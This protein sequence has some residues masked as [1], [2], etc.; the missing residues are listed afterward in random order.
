MTSTGETTV[1]LAEEFVVFTDDDKTDAVP[2]QGPKNSGTILSVDTSTPPQEP[3]QVNRTDSF[4]K[5]LPLPASSVLSPTSASLKKE[6][7]VPSSEQK[8]D[9]EQQQ[10]QPTEQLPPTD[11][12]GVALPSDTNLAASD[13]LVQTYITPIFEGADAGLSTPLAELAGTDFDQQV[14]IRRR[15]DSIVGEEVSESVSG[16]RI[17]EEP[18][19][20]AKETK[21]ELPPP[22]VFTEEKLAARKHDPAVVAALPQTPSAEDFQVAIKQEGAKFNP[23][24]PVETKVAAS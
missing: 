12:E 1:K 19:L 21:L 17:A 6:L 13:M 10:Q 15:N 24:Y 4:P 5:T 20:L 22:E 9:P 16:L 2:A 8:Q 11:T 3:Q 18:S 7:L 23:E 14:A